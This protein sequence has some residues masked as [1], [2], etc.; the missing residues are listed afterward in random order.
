MHRA[1]GLQV[2][3]ELDDATA[4]ER[5]STG[6]SSSIAS[7]SASA[8][9]SVSIQTTNSFPFP[10]EHVSTTSSPTSSRHGRHRRRSS[11][12]PRAVIPQSPAPSIPQ[13][14]SSKTS[15]AS[16]T[17]T[18]TRS[19]SLNPDEKQ[20]QDPKLP[21]SSS[22]TTTTAA[23]AA[24][25]VESSRSSTLPGLAKTDGR[26][27]TANVARRSTRPVSPS[28][29]STKSA[30]TSFSTPV[31]THSKSTRMTTTPRSSRT[32][33]VFVPGAVGSTREGV[34]LAFPGYRARSPTAGNNYHEKK[35]SVNSKRSSLIRPDPENPTWRDSL[36]EDVFPAPHRDPT[37]AT[38]HLRRR[39]RETSGGSTLPSLS[40]S[41]TFTSTTSSTLP[42]PAPS[43]IVSPQQQSLSSPA[44]N[45][46]LYFPPANIT[47]ARNPEQ[48][49]PQNSSPVSRNFVLHG[50][51]Q[52]QQQ[53]QQRSQ[54]SL[55]SPTLSAASFDSISGRSL[56]GG[57]V[58]KVGVDGILKAALDPRRISSAPWETVEGNDEGFKEK[59]IKVV[60]FRESLVENPVVYRG[61]H[62]R[63][64]A[65]WREVSVFQGGTKAAVV[66]LGLESW[67][68][69]NAA[70]EEE[71]ERE[72]L[73]ES[74]TR[75]FAR[76][77]SPNKS[78]S[79]SLRRHH[80]A[81]SLRNLPVTTNSPFEESPPT[82]A[83]SLRYLNSV[84]NSMAISEI[85]GF[86]VYHDARA[87]T[88]SPPSSQSAKEDL[89][90]G[91]SELQLS[92]PSK[93][94]S[95]NRRKTS[96]WVMDTLAS[97]P[98]DP[99]ESNGWEDVDEVGPRDPQLST[100]NIVPTTPSSSTKKNSKNLKLSPESLFPTI[101]N[102]STVA[103]HLV[104]VAHN[105]TSLSPAS[106][107]LRSP[108]PTSAVTSPTS[109]T[110]INTSLLNRKR[111]KLG[112]KVGSIFRKGET[113]P[114]FSPRGI[115]GGP[116]LGAHHNHQRVSPPTPYSP[117]PPDIY[118]LDSSSDSRCHES[119]GDS[120]ED[121]L[122]DSALR[123][124]A[125]G[126]L[127]RHHHQRKD[128]AGVPPPTPTAEGQAF[129]GL[130]DQFA[131][132]EK[133]RFR[134]LAARRTV[135]VAEAL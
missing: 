64:G 133:E 58:R 70:Q 40:H 85:S 80:A 105:N 117:L 2:I 25:E 123:G 8:S 11:T 6:S 90:A 13:R 93:S 24:N 48:F 96:L 53:Q 68:E 56:P 82:S 50:V 52:Q 42:T 26:I 41:P 129:K 99:T 33:R 76:L 134:Q 78:S 110:Q 132:D 128:G 92:S 119:G 43:S 69:S 97:M 88:P 84:H 34:P 98:D 112:L 115:S 100:I 28:S 120:S 121:E 31:K 18:S 66:G 3:A 38:P 109:S 30:S 16:T 72:Y 23:A 67:E 59:E 36:D 22:T 116:S 5:I 44:T 102:P 86:S 39:A 73:V 32:S 74:P 103:V 79:M 77:G 49:S 14:T 135:I 114:P 94:L 87:E 111:S 113:R 65:R 122:V 61:S 104:P 106:G 47:P 91:G 7:S 62:E 35:D 125:G 21:S 95:F 126:T 10:Y 71:V 51:H 118:Y 81:K 20:Q 1:I 15:L 131:L 54:I 101:S 29:R 55:L 57:G 46:K 12:T 83:T 9:P 108:N 130:L 60:E 27:A 37:P 124:A 17:L 45:K 19:S 89:I 75:S 127:F 63:K 107:T 4:F